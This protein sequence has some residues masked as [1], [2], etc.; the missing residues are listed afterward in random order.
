MIDRRKF[1]QGVAG[2]FVAAALPV[3][4]VADTF[5]VEGSYSAYFKH[6]FYMTGDMEQWVIEGLPFEPGDRVL[7]TGT[8]N[9]DGI[10]TVI[11][12]QGRLGLTEHE[13]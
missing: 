11:E 5:N 2:V 6:D 8:S 13:L 9:Q 4:A 12:K 3:K 7:L 1:L 10:Y